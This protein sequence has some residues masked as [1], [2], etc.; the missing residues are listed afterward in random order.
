MK[1]AAR[2][3]CWQTEYCVQQEHGAENADI[4]ILTFLNDQLGLEISL[5]SIY[6]LF[7]GDLCPTDNVHLNAKTQVL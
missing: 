3:Q 1:L 7:L 4:Y 5:T 6:H 2:W